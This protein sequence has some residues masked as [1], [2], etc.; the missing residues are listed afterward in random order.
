[1]L[2]Q[3]KGNNMNENEI[4]EIVKEEINKV[5]FVIPSVERGIYADFVSQKSG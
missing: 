2:G 5:L 3:K 1:M 4:R